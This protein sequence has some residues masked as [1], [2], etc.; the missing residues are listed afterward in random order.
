MAP[1]SVVETLLE[2]ADWQT[3]ALRVDRQA[4][5]I[6]GVKVLGLKSRNGRVYLPEALQEAVHLYEGAKVNINHS[7]SLTPGPRDYRDRLGVLRQAV[8]RQEEGIFADL[9]FNP[10]HPLAEQLAWDAEHCPDNV[11][12]SHHVE[13]R[14]SRR[15]GQTVVEAIL[16]VHSVDVVAD[17]ATSQGLFESMGTAGIEAVGVGQP[18]AALPAPTQESAPDDPP[19]KRI[20]ALEAELA[21]LRAR[22]AQASRKLLIQ[23]LLA[24]HRLPAAESA[25]PF[26]RLVVSQEFIQSLLAAADEAAVRTLVEDRARLVRTLLQEAG[27]GR[28]ANLWHSLQDSQ[29]L[30]QLPLGNRLATERP[31][32]RD[33]L[34][35]ASIVRDV[36]EF[37]RAIT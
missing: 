22:E 25:D 7:A 32:A 33:Q 23:Q 36:Q 27:S 31:M 10:K 15:D 6:R 34:A 35:S 37:I 17:P 28:L 9:R 3:T 12:L 2:F 14:L 26:A 16:R 30:S 13:A 5:L 19:W 20:A 21:E 8:F 18:V 1:E 4:G 11:G 29:G 24:E